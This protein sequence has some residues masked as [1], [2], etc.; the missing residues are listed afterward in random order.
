MAAAIVAAVVILCCALLLLVSYLLHSERQLVGTPGP[1]AQSKA[2]EFAI[3]PHQRACMSSIT[4]VPD[5]R[6]VQL[7]RGE[8]SGSRHGSPPIEVQLSAPS[9]RAIARLPGGESEGVVAVPIQPPRRTVIGSAC[10]INRGRT[11]AVLFG[12]TEPRTRSR[13]ALTING[14]PSAG[15]IGLSFLGNRSRSRLSRLG[16]VFDHAS[17]VTD[18]L[19]P[20]WLIWLPTV[21]ALLVAPVV[22]VAFFYR[23]LREDEVV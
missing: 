1:S 22:T 15:D 10:F 5:G 6:I 23:A 19:V 21:S 8:A 3:L 11:P 4:L 17:N 12:S 13:S 14:K 16:E 7:E 9:Y 18:H 20:V 2:S